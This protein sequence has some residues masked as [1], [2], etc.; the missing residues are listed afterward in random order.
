MNTTPRTPPLHPWC[1][2]LVFLFNIIDLLSWTS[3]YPTFSVVCLDGGLDTDC[4][5]E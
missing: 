5:L 2:N 1:E 3:L 4:G